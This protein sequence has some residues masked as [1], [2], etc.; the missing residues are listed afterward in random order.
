MI[1]MPLSAMNLDT[2]G[3]AKSMYPLHGTDASLVELGIRLP[4]A[5][6]ANEP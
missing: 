4:G 2:S 1:E 5:L 6:R 3:H